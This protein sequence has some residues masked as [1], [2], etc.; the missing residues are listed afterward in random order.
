MMRIALL[1]YGKMGKAIDALAQKAG[2]EVVLR[3]GSKNLS[4]LTVE[5]L[6]K[7]DVAIEF[8][9]PDSAFSNIMLCLE[10][11]VPV[12]SGTTAWLDRLEDAKA[13]C[14]EKK[15]G[16]MYASNFSIGV[17]LFFALNR[18]LAAMMNQQPDYD[19]KAEEIHH[20]Q[21][22]DAP[23]GTAITLVED[24]ID[25]VARKSS[26]VKDKAAA[27][28]EIPIVSK[29]I[30]KVPGTHEIVYDSPI[31]SI[32]IRHEAHSREGFAKGALMAAQW[33]I[34]KQ[35]YFEMKDMLGF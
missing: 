18:Q 24:I 22:L 11:G 35:G 5:Q 15:G 33:I 17:N 26:W 25:E 29:R 23:S 19:I 6:Q 7:A 2:H 16:L 1:G 30:E 8:S 32:V 13:F 3:I 31:D 34:G 9:R 10:A 28:E 21:K 20:T 14:S 12:I 27:A 4:D